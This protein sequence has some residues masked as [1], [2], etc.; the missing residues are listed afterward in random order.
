MKYAPI[1]A[2]KTVMFCGH[3]SLHA[4][5]SADAL[6]TK[7]TDSLTDSVCFYLMCRNGL[8]IFQTLVRKQEVTMNDL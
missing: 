3:V 1:T 4:N 7:S 8:R 5:T 6:F 2:T